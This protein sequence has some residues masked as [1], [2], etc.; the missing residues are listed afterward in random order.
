MLFFNEKMLSVEILKC[1]EC[2]IPHDCI[3][4]IDPSKRCIQCE[5]NYSF[6]ALEPI[7]LKCGHHI[8]K[9]C[10]AKLDRNSSFKCKICSSQISI[11]DGV[12]TASEVLIQTFMKDLT[13]ELKEKYVRTLNL[14]TGLDQ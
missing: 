6:I 3:K 9:E 12:G 7:T 8:C 10:R 2:A 14:Y 11:N 1:V 5:I 4:E 13:R